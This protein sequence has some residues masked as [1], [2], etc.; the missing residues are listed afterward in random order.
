MTPLQLT[1][2]GSLGVTVISNRF[3]DQYLPK[4]NGSF[5]KV[6][7]CLLRH[8]QSPGAPVTLSGLADL[9][10]ETE[11][12]IARAVNYWE[13]EGLLIVTRNE[14]QEVSGIQFVTPWEMSETETNSGR[15]LPADTSDGF[16]PGASVPDAS[17]PG[18]SSPDFTA[19]LAAAAAPDGSDAP[20]AS[21]GQTLDDSAESDFPDLIPTLASDP[22]NA[23]EIPENFDKPD[24]SEA[25]IAQLTE[26]DEVKWM[27]NVIEVYL[28]RLL[29]PMDVQLIL[30][31]YESLGFS[32]ELILYLYEYCVS[33]NKKS[34][35][36]VEAVALAWA[37][38]GINTVEKA[39]AA[40]AAYTSGFQTVNKAFGL[41]RAPGSVEKQ[42]IQRWFDL[43]GS[44]PH[45]IEE[46]CS[47]TL[48]QT[49]KPDFKY[50]DKIWE[51]W[52]KEGVVRYSDIAAC[53]ARHAQKAANA[54]GNG[55]SGAADSAGTRD[56]SG[57]PSAGTNGSG[58][59]NGSAPRSSNKFNAFP[60]RS[61]SGEDFSSMEQR[62]L[63]KKNST[64]TR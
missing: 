31:L 51:N 45:I 19:D 39:E 33:R 10:D 38:E 1:N 54:R 53:D 36:Y 27:F 63:Q 50:A 61:Y 56:A 29:K 48:L 52:K 18:S 34:P 13:K 2:S 4:A 41:N 49:G 35:S 9:L 12:D 26:N 46:A 6:Y 59:P 43:F 23:A 14:A 44:D 62:L 55:G 24:Y 8:V 25:Q 11:K 20:G 7:L 30:Y 28:E 60:Q 42:Y 15:T 3:L 40:A 32:A 16:A 57:R 58:N 37:K 5:V 47:R 17:A 64:E 22:G 21:S